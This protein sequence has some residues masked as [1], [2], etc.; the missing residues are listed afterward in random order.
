MPAV[1]ARAALNGHGICRPVRVYYRQGCAANVAPRPSEV[2]LPQELRFTDVRRSAIGDFPLAR[3]GPRAPKSL[4]RFELRPPSRLL[5]SLRLPSA[6]ALLRANLRC[7]LDGI[8]P[9]ERL[10]LRLLRRYPGRAA[11]GL[12]SS[13]GRAVPNLPPGAAALC[14]R[15]S[16]RNLPGTA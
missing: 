3:S 6:A 13:Q 2:R 12:G 10:H 11:A 8:S 14:A 5:C 16:L 9:P 15:R 1:S 7:L 4:G